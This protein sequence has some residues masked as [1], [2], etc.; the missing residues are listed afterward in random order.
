M[1]QQPQ[2]QDY[3]WWI[4]GGLIAAVVIFAVWFKGTQQRPDVYGA[5]QQIEEEVKGYK[6]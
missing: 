2:Q 1:S 6:K 4:I 5:Y 3:F